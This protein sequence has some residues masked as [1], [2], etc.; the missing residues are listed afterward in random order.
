MLLLL[1][2]VASPVV[3]QNGYWS[4][5]SRK[6][7]TTQFE[8][9]I[10]VAS[11][12]CYVDSA[13][14]AKANLSRTLDQIH[15]AQNTGADLIE[16]DVYADGKNLVVGHND[17]KNR[18]S[19][20]LKSVLSDPQLRAGDQVL[21]IEMKEQRPTAEIAR[22]LMTLVRDLGYAT[23]DR[24]IVFR[25]FHKRRLN[26][27]LIQSM[28]ARKEF[29]AV[30][31]FV[32]L[33]EFVIRDHVE[34]EKDYH[35]RILLAKESGFH[36]VEFHY[37]SPNL[38]GA[39]GYAKSLGLGVG[40]FTVPA[41][42][43]EVFVAGLRE[44]IDVIVLDYPVGRARTVIEDRNALL[45]LSASS[46]DQDAGFV[47]YSSATLERQTIKLDPKLTPKIVVSP[48]G[49]PFFGS[50]LAFSGKKTLRTFDADNRRQNGYFATAVVG[51]EK[52]K[53]PDGETST[54]FSKADEG[55]FTLELF[56]PPGANPTHLRFGVR[57]GDQY[58]YATTP[59]SRLNTTNS[60][61]IIGA[62][63][64]NG[65]VRMWVDCKN[66]GIKTT[67]GVGGVIQNNSPVTIGADPQG[68]KRSRFHFEGIVQQ[69]QLQSW[70]DK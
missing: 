45:H 16:L 24:P 57:V 26:L 51:F 18:S 28:L 43:G 40:V 8:N 10:G 65:A 22:K 36:G 5:A 69:F 63:D 50:A 2:V 11:H 25:A 3:A 31:E 41:R 39:I 29:S 9:V 58:L 68:D 1:I 27:T 47:D 66:D 23:K 44:D 54:I 49:T 32:M 17:K 13:A 37:N 55:G 60:F 20:S 21:F 33:H 56:N 53:L 35:A 70:A 15:A 34:T 19:A 30:R 48:V 61:F 42:F 46:L 7:A 62:Y 64:G 59:A 14:T 52:L 67:P 38:F 4:K 12:N 6:F